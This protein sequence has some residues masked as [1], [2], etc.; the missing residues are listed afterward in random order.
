MDV[1][2]PYLVRSSFIEVTFAYRP[3]PWSPQRPE[4]ALDE[5]QVVD[6]EDREH[7]LEAGG[8]AHDGLLV[9]RVHLHARHVLP[10]RRVAAAQ[11]KKVLEGWTT[12]RG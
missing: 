12:G 7:E 3:R 8:G 4:P 11:E 2:F 9:R 1:S 6:L 10:V 5:Q